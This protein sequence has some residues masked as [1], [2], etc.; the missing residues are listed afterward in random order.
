MG[1]EDERSMKYEQEE[2]SKF[3]SERF[4][5]PQIKFPHNR[6]TDIKIENYAPKSTFTNLRPMAN[7]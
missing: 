1:R 6:N 3:F 2:L 4:F 7:T 5:T